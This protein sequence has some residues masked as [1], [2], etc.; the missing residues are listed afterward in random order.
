MATIQITNLIISTKD[1][2]VEEF[3]NH[4]EK[5][6]SKYAGSDWWYRFDVDFDDAGDPDENED[7]NEAVSL[8]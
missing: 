6:L 8:T 3:L 7:E 5:L 2:K 4:L 1:A